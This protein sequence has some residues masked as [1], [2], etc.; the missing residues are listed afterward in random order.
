M[1]ENELKHQ[2]LRIARLNGWMQHNDGQ[3]RVMHKSGDDGYPDLTL[4]RDGR[5]IWIECKTETGMQSSGQRAWQ[6][7]LPNYHLVRPSQMRLV[8]DLLA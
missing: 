7:M 3:S 2:I 4:A 6:M 5:V 1:T 8:M